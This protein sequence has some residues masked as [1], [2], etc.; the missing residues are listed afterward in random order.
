M[1]IHPLKILT[2][3]FNQSESIA[4]FLSTKLTKAVLLTHI[5]RRKQLGK[6]QQLR[7]RQQRI[8]L[9]AS[10]FDTKNQY[11]IKGKAI[12]LVDDVITT[13]STAKAATASLLKAG[14]KSVDLWCIAKTSW[15]NHS[16]SIKM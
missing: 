16:S 2:R 13:G 10:T 5:C 9:L 11:E 8:K 6:P 12:A 1:P 15:H 4:Y 3:G 7:T 14:A